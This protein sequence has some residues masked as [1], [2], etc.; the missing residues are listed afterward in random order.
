M[1]DQFLAQTIVLE[2]W[3]LRLPPARRSRTSCAAPGCSGSPVACS[4]RMQPSTLLFLLSWWAV[5]EGVLEGRLAAGWLRGWALILLGLGAA[6]DAVDLAAGRAGDRIGAL[7]RRR[8]L[9]GALAL[10]PQVVTAMASAVCSAGRSRPTTSS[11]W[12]SAA[13]FRACSRSRAGRA[14]AGGRCRRMVARRPARGLARPVLAIRLGRARKRWTDQRLELT[15]PRRAYGRPSH[16]ARP[17]P[18]SPLRDG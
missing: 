16:P 8:L 6:G 1:L 11:G 5:G 3:A 12:R 4:P 17:Q 2:G 15:G 13:A 10:P 18:L 9:A 14:G 7:L